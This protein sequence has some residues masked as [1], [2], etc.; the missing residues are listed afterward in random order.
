MATQV[1]LRR[2]T[3]AEHAAFTGAVGEVTV[4]TNKDTVVVHDGSTAGGHPSAKAGTNADISSLTGLNDDGIPGA[5][6]VA[7][8]TDAEGVSE[9]STDAETVTGAAT[10]LTVTPANLVA[11]MAA[12]GAI[13]GTTPAAVT[14]SDLK[15]TNDAADAILS[16]T[17][18]IFLIKDNAGT[19]YYFKAYPTKS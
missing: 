4:D 3:T 16:G 15:I 17:P 14:A 1:Q 18:K 7:A 10:A 12:P 11:K 19:Q 5:K 13:G 6:V 2:G 8:T 9:R